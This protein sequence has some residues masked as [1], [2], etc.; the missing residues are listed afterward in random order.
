[1]T[2]VLAQQRVSATILFRGFFSQLRLSSASRWPA[3]RGRR[4]RLEARWMLRA[5]LQATLLLAAVAAVAAV[6]HSNFRRCEGA[7]I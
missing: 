2:L 4:G 6:N 3:R 1:M 5:V 7:G